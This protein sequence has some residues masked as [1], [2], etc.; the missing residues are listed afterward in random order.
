MGRAG[1]LLLAGRSG[2][3]T[4]NGLSVAERRLDGRWLRG[5]TREIVIE[6]PGETS[7]EIELDEIREGR[8]CTI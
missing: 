6:R 3:S 7:S 1:L 4:G 5:L 8:V 2:T